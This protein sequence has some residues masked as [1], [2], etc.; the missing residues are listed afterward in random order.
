MAVLLVTISSA[1]SLF[2]LEICLHFSLASSVLSVDIVVLHWN[3]A[4]LVVSLKHYV[5]RD[6][7]ASFVL[8]SIDMALL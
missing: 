4:S 1:K 3:A 2:S 6:V 8:F 7:L 5:E